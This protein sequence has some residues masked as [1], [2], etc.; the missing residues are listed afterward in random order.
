MTAHPDDIL[1]VAWPE[2]ARLYPQ[3]LNS[4][5]VP[6]SRRDKIRGR[7]FRIAWVT[8]AANVPANSRFWGMLHG[9]AFFSDGEIKDISEYE[10]SE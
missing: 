9:E 6:I 7:G 8:P 3:F 10:E 5:V 1:V 2:E 4:Q